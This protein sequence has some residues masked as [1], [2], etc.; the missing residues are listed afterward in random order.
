M[1][2][3]NLAAKRA[4]PAG[5]LRRGLQGAEEVL[6]EWNRSTWMRPLHLFGLLCQ[7]DRRRFFALKLMQLLGCGAEVEEEYERLLPGSASGAQKVRELQAKADMVDKVLEERLEAHHGSGDLTRVMK[8]HGLQL[9]SGALHPGI[10]MELL[11]LARA[12]VRRDLG[13]QF[14]FGT[15]G[16]P[17][18]HDKFIKIKQMFGIDAHVV[19]KD[20]GNMCKAVLKSITDEGSLGVDRIRR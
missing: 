1:H 18:L 4:E 17:L 12:P 20:M 10:K 2:A 14:M 6:Q 9:P 8:V 15:K 3:N 16:S 13:V 5:R 19:D 11:F 7:E